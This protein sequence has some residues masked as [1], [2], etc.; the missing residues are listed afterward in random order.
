MQP[1]S[2]QGP[3]TQEKRTAMPCEGEDGIADLI[4]AVKLQSG[5]FGTGHTEFGF[6]TIDVELRGDQ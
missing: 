3:S 1:G 6:C 2:F 4:W 5:I